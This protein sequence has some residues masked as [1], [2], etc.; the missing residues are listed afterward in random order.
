MGRLMAQYVDKSLTWDSIELEWVKEVADVQVVLGGAQ[1][2]ANGL[3]HQRFD[4]VGV[5]LSNDGGRSLDERMLYT[6]QIAPRPLKCNKAQP[7]I[8]VLLEPH[9]LCSGIFNKLKVY[10]VV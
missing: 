1:I 2:A 4:A 6:L 8:L 3:Y 10:V 9:R 7:G 5:M